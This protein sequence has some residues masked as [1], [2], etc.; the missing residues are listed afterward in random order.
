MSVKFEH[1]S[2][3]SQSLFE[4]KNEHLH[5]S[6]GW[7]H[8]KKGLFD[9]FFLLISNLEA[10]NF[11]TCAYCGRRNLELF[12]MLFIDLSSPWNFLP[13]IDCYSP[14]S[15]PWISST[16]ESKIMCKKPV[17][18]WGGEPDTEPKVN[19]KVNCFTVDFTGSWGWREG[20]CQLSVGR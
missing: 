18:V 20:C 3:Y 17:G 16:V 8:D 7:K 12:D 11:S 15:R 1:C 13:A 2:P 5:T 9:S 19:G 14:K 4:K 10:I 6:H